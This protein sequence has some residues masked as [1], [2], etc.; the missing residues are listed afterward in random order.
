MKVEAVH[1]VHQNAMAAKTGVLGADA[2]TESRVPERPRLNLKPRSNLTG[3]SD[4]I[5]VKERYVVFRF[6]ILFLFFL[7]V[8]IIFVCCNLLPVIC[9]VNT[10]CPSTYFGFHSV[11]TCITCFCY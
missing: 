8:V 3:Q 5:V 1:D 9:M 11:S 6:Q 7:I 2:E 4:E 10:T